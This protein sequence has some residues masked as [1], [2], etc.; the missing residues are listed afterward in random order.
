MAMSGTPTYVENPTF[1]QNATA[2]CRSLGKEVSCPPYSVEKDVWINLFTT[3]TSWFQ[4]FTCTREKQVENNVEKKFLIEDGNI[5]SC[6]LACYEFKYFIIKNETCMCARKL[7]VGKRLKNAP[8]CQPGDYIVFQKDTKDVIGLPNPTEPCAYLYCNKNIK[9]DGL[10]VKNLTTTCDYSNNQRVAICGIPGTT[11]ECL[12]YT[13]FQRNYGSDDIKTNEIQCEAY[14]IDCLHSSQASNCTVKSVNKKF[15]RQIGVTST[16]VHNKNIIHVPVV[17]CGYLNPSS[18]SGAIV[19]AVVG[20]LRRSKSD[21]TGNEQNG[22]EFSQVTP[23]TNTAYDLGIGS[24]SNSSEYDYIKE[25]HHYKTNTGYEDLEDNKDYEYS[26]NSA[27]DHLHEKGERKINPS[28]QNNL[29]SHRI[30]GNDDST[31]DI[32]NIESNSID[33]STYNTTNSDDYNK[34]D[35]RNNTTNNNETNGDYNK[36]DIRNNTTNN[37]ETNDDNN[38]LDMRNNTTNNNET[39]GDYNKLDTRNNTTNNNET[40]DDNNKLDTRNNTTNTMK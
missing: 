35:I 2:H 7:S 4:L 18:D 15:I 27:Y 20:V 11:H 37:N 31:Y 6:Q 17:A 39:N 32:G 3:F 36:L 34:L 38:K 14:Q 40:N 21:K 1:W 22:G 5:A 13:Q 12:N 23:V 28:E 24:I 25:Q 10:Q 30:P 9:K 33:H 26:D 8:N 16:L 19:G 29:Y